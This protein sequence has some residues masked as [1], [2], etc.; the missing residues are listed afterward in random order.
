MVFRCLL[1][2]NFLTYLRLS[3]TI[4]VLVIFYAVSVITIMH[5]TIEAR[6]LGSWHELLVLEVSSGNL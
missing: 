6:F 1:C 4:K 3:V 2:L 5:T